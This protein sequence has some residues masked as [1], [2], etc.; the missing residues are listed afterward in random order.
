MTLTHALCTTL[1]PVLPDFDRGTLDRLDCAS[2]SARL[3]SQAVSRSAN[4]PVLASV[5]FFV[6]QL[7][8]QQG[9]GQEMKPNVVEIHQRKAYFI[10]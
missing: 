2:L 1:Y 8:H 7:R 10:R 9:T 3:P 4:W 6:T 5:Y